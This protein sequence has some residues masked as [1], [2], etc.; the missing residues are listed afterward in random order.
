MRVL[1]EATKARKRKAPTAVTPQVARINPA[2]S[3]RARFRP[4]SPVAARSG[5][6]AV[7]PDPASVPLPAPPLCLQ[8][9]PPLLQGS[10][11][12]TDPYHRRIAGSHGRRDCALRAQG[13]EAPS[14]EWTRFRRRNDGDVTERRVDGDSE[15]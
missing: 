2:N 11:H 1:C 3:S 9:E 14:Q 15:T 13:I 8:R 12:E 5:H 10:A 6:D 4:S 7:R